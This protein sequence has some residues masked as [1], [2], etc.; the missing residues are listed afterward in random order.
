M[1]RLYKAHVLP[2][3]EFPTAAIYH[4]TQTNLQKLD[5]VQ[6]RFLR[7]VGLTAEDAF[8]KYRLA[9]LQTRRDLAA[10]G[11][12][13]R[14]VLGKGPKHFKQWFFPSLKRKHPF[15][16]RR[17]QRL[18]TRQLHDYLDGNHNEMIRRSILGLPKVYNDLPQDVVNATS[19]ANFQRKLQQLVKNKVQNNVDGW[20]H[21]LNLRKTCF[22]C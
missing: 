8:L 7:T 20:E 21:S 19:V 6:K 3:L 4:T 14:T 18:H 2:I 13:H 10:L 12:I 1:V 15:N 11:L 16:T 5:R 22:A 17:Q 9:P